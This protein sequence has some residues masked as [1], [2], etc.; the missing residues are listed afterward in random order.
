MPHGFILEYMIKLAK[1]NI[2]EFERIARE[3]REKVITGYRRESSETELRQLQWVIDGKIL[4]GKPGLGAHFLIMPMMWEKFNELRSKLQ[5]IRAYQQEIE[6][7]RGK[8][9]S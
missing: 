5:L 4:K 3:L 2:E 9:E 7:A 1:E 6:M 8:F